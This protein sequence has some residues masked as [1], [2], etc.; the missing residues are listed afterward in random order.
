ML[1]PS[2]QPEGQPLQV[3][4]APPAPPVNPSVDA[5]PARVDKDQ[6]DTV[7]AQN[8]ELQATLKA[9]EAAQAEAAQK[10]AEE[11]GQWQEL[12]KQHE[13]KAGELASEVER[14]Q[15]AL[16]LSNA[17]IVD[18][19]VQ[20][21]AQIRF[22][23]QD[24]ESDFG[25]FLKKELKAGKLA[26]F[27]STP[28]APGARPTGTRNGGHPDPEIPAACKAEAVKHGR[29]AEWWYQNVWVKTHKNK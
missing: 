20:E 3:P 11:Q 15:R 16:A 2:A 28:A 9:I 21:L 14:L 25:A 4:T 18:P 29:T 24:K 19:D 10:K 23:R 12:A 26:R 8:R 13:G 6:Y 17:G 1:D 7:L 27:I 5:P 22:A